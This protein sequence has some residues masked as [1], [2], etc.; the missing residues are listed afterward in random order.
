[1]GLQSKVSALL[2]K[3]PGNVR[4]DSGAYPVSRQAE[5]RGHRERGRRASDATRRDQE[6]AD[7]ESVASGVDRSDTDGSLIA[8]IGDRVVNGISYI[9]AYFRRIWIGGTGPADANIIADATG[10]S[11]NGASITLTKNGV[12]TTINNVSGISGETESLNSKD[13][14]TPHGSVYGDHPFQ[15]LLLCLGCRHSGIYT[16]VVGLKAS[17]SGEG[18]LILANLTGNLINLATGGGG[19]TPFLSAS[20]LTTRRN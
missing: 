17:G 7:A 19:G 1:M 14:V 11:I 13:S 10:I 8:W 15:P 6:R 3:S 4:T 2:Q 18:R 20:T 9:G 5:R 12:T 16:P